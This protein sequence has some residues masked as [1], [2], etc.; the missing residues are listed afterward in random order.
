MESSSSQRRV[1]KRCGQE[2]AAD[3]TAFSPEGRNG[4]LRS[5]C[6]ECY[7]AD[8]RAKRRTT[9]AEVLRKRA[10][11]QSQRHKLRIRAYNARYRR[12]NAEKVRAGARRRSKAYQL[13]YPERV[14]AGHF[15]KYGLDEAALKA[16][17]SAQSGLCAACETAAPLHVDHC[18]KS[19]RVRALL[20][21]PCNRAL[22]MA[23]E[24]PRRLRALADYMDRHVR[25]VR[26]GVMQ[27]TAVA[28]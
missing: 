25:A 20:C 26:L 6:R 12:D 16:M 4:T 23:L 3:A 14:R 2:K 27:E 28:F 19:N 24:D 22:G 5:T 8:G 18:H 7:N 1:C 11:E 9:P 17:K 21:A 13:R 10:R 15:R